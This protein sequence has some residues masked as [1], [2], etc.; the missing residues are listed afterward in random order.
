MRSLLGGT[1]GRLSL[2]GPSIVALLALAGCASSSTHAGKQARIAAALHRLEHA[3]LSGEAKAPSSFRGKNVLGTV[4]LVYA[5][6]R[7]RA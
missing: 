5:R 2:A 3:L 7:R 6:D 4:T 1:G